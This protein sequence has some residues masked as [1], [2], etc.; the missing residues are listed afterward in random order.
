M[1]SRVQ[2]ITIQ[3]CYKATSVAVRAPQVGV[4]VKT[5]SGDEIAQVAPEHNYQSA[6]SFS[7]NQAQFKF[8]ARSTAVNGMTIVILS[9]QFV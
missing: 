1:L 2:T 5:L 6:S 7:A 9:I 4:P 8:A 3:N